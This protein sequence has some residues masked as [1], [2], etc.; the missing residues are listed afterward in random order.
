MFGLLKPKVTA[1]E[2][3]SQLLEW[4]RDE[5][6]V[7]RQLLA[8]LPEDIDRTRVK[9]ELRYLRA[10]AIEFAATQSTSNPEVRK[11]ARDGFYAMLRLEVE[12]SGAF[13]LETL[14]SRY[15]AYSKASQQNHHLGLPYCIGKEFATSCGA[16]DNIG[17]VLPAA[18]YFG[19]SCAM[20]AQRLKDVRLER[21]DK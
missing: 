20:I 18:H 21:R 7:D 12:L 8:G 13:S 1:K 17:L 10:F 9:S 15:V 2:L 11:A 5:N 14:D 4:A 6:D 19:V 3:G 16:P